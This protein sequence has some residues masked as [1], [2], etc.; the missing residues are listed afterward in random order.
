MFFLYSSFFRSIEN[1]GPTVGIEGSYRR[2][3]DGLI[4]VAARSETV[5]LYNTDMRSSTSFH[6]PSMKPKYPGFAFDVIESSSDQEV[7]W[8]EPSHS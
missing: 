2:L 7:A 1:G 4:T 6:C 3:L 5:T 8:S